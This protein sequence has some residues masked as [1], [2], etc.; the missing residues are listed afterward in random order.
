MRSR[1][2]LFDFFFLMGT[3][4]QN[5]WAT[6]RS[7]VHVFEGRLFYSLPLR[8]RGR[9]SCPVKASYGSGGQNNRRLARW[10]AHFDLCLPSGPRV[11]H[12]TS[13]FARAPS[14]LLFCGVRNTHKY[15]AFC[16]FS[17]EYGQCPSPTWITPHLLC[18][19]NARAFPLLPAA[20]PLLC[21][22]CLY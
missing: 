10:K 9:S 20:F 8:G 12:V 6:G 1:W 7:I 18:F 19:R 22:L 4:D 5:Q 21:H 3:E 2:F 11:P 16:K 15:L 17:E 13:F 14:S